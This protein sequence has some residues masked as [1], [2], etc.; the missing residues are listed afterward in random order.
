[1]LT[2]FTWVPK[3]AMKSIP[4]HTTDSIETVRE[5]LRRLNPEADEDADARG[6]PV[7][8]ED[9]EDGD[10]FA[11][12]VGGGGDAI[13]EQLESD[14][15]SDMDDTVF[16]DT[17]LAFVVTRAEQDEPSLEVFT[18]DE[19]MDNLFLHHD[20]PIAG[21]PLC[22]AWLTDGESS[23]AALGTMMPFIEIWPLDVIDAVDPLTVL[24]GCA[25]PRDNYR[26]KVKKSA[27]MPESHQDAVLSVQWNVLAPHILASGSADATIKLWDLHTQACVGTYNEAEKVQTLHWHPSEENL[28]L[29]GAFD[30]MCILR[31][32]RHPDDA[33]VRWAHSCVI[34]HVEFG[35]AGQAALTSDSRGTI[36]AFDLRMDSQPLW[37]LPAHEGEAQF[38]CS[39]HMHSLMASGGADGLV[40]LWDVSGAEPQELRARELRIGTITSLQFHPNSPHILGAAGSKGQ[41]L[42]YTV[43][44]DVPGMAELA[45]VPIAVPEGGGRGDDDHEGE[46]RSRGGG[47]KKKVKFAKRH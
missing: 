20:A 8:E 45:G 18:Y 31:D 21:Y 13:L 3:G 16:K 36:R 43:T 12:G 38:A 6:I 5:K 17:D 23:I 14:D 34:E 10:A 40:K 4:L 30:G 24:G 28:L 7:D 39:R 25:N 2:S 9:D 46:S 47:G 41:P 22:S 29:S 26:R 32:C 15:D 44:S 27:L 33:A 37:E 11:V 1:M 42:V 35:N 19:P